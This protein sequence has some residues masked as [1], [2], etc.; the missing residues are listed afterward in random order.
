[1][2]QLLDHSGQV[3]P[4]EQI[5][6]ARRAAG[7]GAS[8]GGGSSQLFP[9]DAS[10]WTSPEMSEWQPWLHSPD[11]EYNVYRDRMVA[12][13]RDQVRNDPWATGAVDSIL[14]STVGSS[15]R[16]IANPDYRALALHDK[17]FDATWAREFRQFV[18]AKWRG[19]SEDLGRYN[20]V[21][22]QMTQPQQF[23]L[24][25]RHKLIDGESLTLPYWLPERLGKGHA[26]YATAFLVVDPDRLSNPYQMVDTRYMRG[27]VEI[28]D[29]G[30]AIAYHVR[31]AHQYDWY[32]AVQSMEWER[33]PREDSDGFRRVIHDYDVLRA[34]QHRGV[35]M[36]ASILR[37]LK[38]LATYYQVEL[39]A[40]TVAS[41]FG[42][43]I[44]SP[45][46]SQLVEQALTTSDDRGGLSAYQNLRTAFHDEKKLMLNRVRIPTLAPGEDIKVAQSNRSNESFTP[47]T[48]EMH[49]MGA[50]ATGVSEQQINRDYST[51][52]YSSIKGALVEV[53]K[54]ATRRMNDFKANTAAPV[55]GCWMHELFEQGEVPL[56]RRA[57]AY[58]EART[59]YSRSRWLG[60]G[61]GWIDPV[62][63]RQGE[64]LGL[65]AGFGTLEAVCA[66]QGM[67]WEENLD[68]RAIEF[69][70]FQDLKLPQPV[71]QGETRTAVGQDADKASKPPQ[72]PQPA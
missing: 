2:A 70:R 17:A 35:S 12:R 63:E 32:N 60:A 30:V 45:F 16:L 61:S 48:H 67:D 7:M 9:Y 46:D 41:V 25:M 8:L 26:R 64:V 57:P 3:I 47:F 58:V 66:K 54:T 71:W 62:A 65:D 21:T 53:E 49:R 5:A 56:P 15:L 18:E 52:N 28:D 6:A 31:K 69:Q 19:Y 22:R 55:V 4:A 51:L 11:A 38:M 50:A 24:A 13:Q 23:R 1:M 34:G 43:F 20:D 27:G 44:T 10:D 36:F 29:D 68:Q 14:D 72:K 42:T 59:E 37:W 33:I 40:A 39:Q